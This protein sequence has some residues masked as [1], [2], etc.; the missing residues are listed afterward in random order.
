MNWTPPVVDPKKYSNAEPFPHI[1]IDDFFDPSE[2]REAM[3]F[4]PQGRDGWR[5]FQ[6]KKR[7][8]YDVDS[9]GSPLVSIFKLLSSREFLAWLS[10]VTGIRD[11][12]ADDD[13]NGSGIHAVP[14]GG[15]LK[16]HTDFNQLGDGM[17]RRVNAFIYLNEDWNDE[18]GGALE[19]WDKDRMEC[20]TSIPPVFNRF[21]AFTCSD[22][23]LHGHPAR[24][25]CPEDRQRLSF[26]AYYYTREQPDDFEERHS[27]IYYET[28]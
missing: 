14:R 3:R 6:G 11:L 7:A 18:W 12:L 28:V 21:V 2:L 22:R 25:Q 24:L 8:F 5:D 23:S 15:R 20:V 26:A 16:I 17:Y 10:F 27:T 13:H 9:L 1:V 19:L 4:I